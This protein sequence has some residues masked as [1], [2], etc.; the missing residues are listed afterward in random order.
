[1][2]EDFVIVSPLRLYIRTMGAGEAQLTAQ[3]SNVDLLDHF[4]AMQHLLQ[5]FLAQLLR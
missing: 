3:Q 5:R 1:M 2:E 4:D